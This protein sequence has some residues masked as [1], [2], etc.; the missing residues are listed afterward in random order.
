M[1]GPG[2]ASPRASISL[3]GETWPGGELRGAGAPVSL[4][5][6]TASMLLGMTPLRAALA[7]LGYVEGTSVAYEGRWAEGKFERLPAL[8]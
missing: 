5:P 6:G 2:Q 1:I 3:V 8:A 4:V 7:R